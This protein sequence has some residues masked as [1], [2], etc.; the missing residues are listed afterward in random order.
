M[1]SSRGGGGEV[2]VGVV[3]IVEVSHLDWMERVESRGET[4]VSEG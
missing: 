3:G 4:V 1:V 2:E